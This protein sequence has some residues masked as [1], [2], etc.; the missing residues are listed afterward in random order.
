MPEVSL[1]AQP[2]ALSGSSVSGDFA[3]SSFS[4]SSSLWPFLSAVNVNVK[5]NAMVAVR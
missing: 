2:K 1:A 3:I 5:C 4:S